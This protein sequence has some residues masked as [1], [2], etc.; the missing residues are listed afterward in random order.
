MPLPPPLP[1]EERRSAFVPLPSTAVSQ[2]SNSPKLPRDIS[3]PINLSLT[4][5]MQQVHSVVGITMATSG[6]VER[7]FSTQQQQQQQQYRSVI[8]TALS[9]AP[10]QQRQYLESNRLAMPS[11][12][13]T[14]QRYLSTGNLVDT[15]LEWGSTTEYGNGTSE[16]VGE[17]CA[18]RLINMAQRAQQQLEQKRFHS[19]LTTSPV[20]EATDAL[21]LLQETTSF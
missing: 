1:I 17:T 7:H 16:E 9:V 12:T 21:M 13:G 20:K 19:P 3:Q 14:T 18:A 4:G 6:P 15:T 11:S 5:S 8:K 2:F 10:Q